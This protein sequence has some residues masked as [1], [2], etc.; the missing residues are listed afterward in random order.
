MTPCPL[1]SVLS[2]SISFI[3]ALFRPARSCY[4]P[5]SYAL[6]CVFLSVPIKYTPVCFYPVLSLLYHSFRFGCPCPIYLPIPVLPFPPPFL[7]AYSSP[8]SFYPVCPFCTIL[9]FSNS[10]FQS[11]TFLPVKFVSCNHIRSFQSH[12][13]LPFISIIYGARNRVGLGLAYGPARQHRLAESVP[14]NR[15]LGFLKV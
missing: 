12:S 9:S 7:P 14:W 1:F 2:I 8:S 5:S 3:P 10:S 11:H 13:F 6:S 15:F 4:L